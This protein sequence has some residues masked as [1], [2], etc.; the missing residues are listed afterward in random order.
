MKMRMA[1]ATLILV[2]GASALSACSQESPAP[3]DPGPVATATSTPTATPT[4]PTISTAADLVG[5][6]ES[7]EAEWVV[8]FK[9][10]GTFVTDFQGHDNF[11][12]GK[13]E[14][15]G[16]EV[17]LIGDDGN[18]DKGTVDGQSL[19]FRLGTLTRK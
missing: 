18:T 3:A 19:K 12:V 16:T 9:D 14:V 15:N 17:S 4:V 10:D 8:H 7:V 11:L 6:W 13:Y 5:D 2:T 1:L